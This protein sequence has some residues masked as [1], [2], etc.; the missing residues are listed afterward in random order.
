[1]DFRV[2]DSS[3]GYTFDQSQFGCTTGIKTALQTG[4]CDPACTTGADC[5]VPTL[6]SWNPAET[7]VTVSGYL[8]AIYMI[9]QD[10]DLLAPSDSTASSDPVTPSSK[11]SSTSINE[12]SSSQ[13]SGSPQGS[14]STQEG[15]SSEN[16]NSTKGTTSSQ[17]S[18]SA[19]QSD[20]NLPST[21]AQQS[22]TP[23]QDNTAQ[24]SDSG[25]SIGA[26][27]AIGVVVPIVVLIA[28]ACGA[29][30]FMTKLKKRR[31]LR[32][33]QGQTASTG[34]SPFEVQQVGYREYSQAGPPNLGNVP[35]R[36]VQQL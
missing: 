32:I 36:E 15:S 10:S 19:R 18:S 24:Q 23:Q 13:Q 11:T 8:D 7:S 25:L 12:S 21:T 33:S 5:T 34:T 35:M 28:I 6:F 4:L 17:S 29:L 26:K 9:H 1:M 2:T 14:I 31:E 16:T 30:V 22:N 3:S 20:S 27:I